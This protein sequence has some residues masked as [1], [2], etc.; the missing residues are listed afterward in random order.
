MTTNMLLQAFAQVPELRVWY[1]PDT[2]MGRNLAQLFSQLAEMPDAEIAA[3]HPAH[4][5]A[6]LWIP[7]DLF[8]SLGVPEPLGFKD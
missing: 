4:T 5:Q 1:G 7:F 8:A 2:Y 3:V 6:G